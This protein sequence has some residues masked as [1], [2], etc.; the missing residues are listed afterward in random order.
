MENKLDLWASFKSVESNDSSSNDTTIQS[1]TESSG[2]RK[3][4]PI[5]Q[6]VGETIDEYIDRAF[7]NMKDPYIQLK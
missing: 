5:K 6:M 2:E 4:A 1:N 7:A 3:N